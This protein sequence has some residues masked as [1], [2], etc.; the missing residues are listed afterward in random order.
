MS[1]AFRA[2]QAARDGLSLRVH[3][4]RRE[5]IKMHMPQLFQAQ[6]IPGTPFIY[7]E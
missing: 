4:V 1:G 3:V 2:H 7:A 6:D 5:N